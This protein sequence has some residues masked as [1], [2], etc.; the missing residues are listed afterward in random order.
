MNY[1]KD[2]IC[3]KC[4]TARSVK[5]NREHRDERIIRKRKYYQNYRYK[6]K[7]SIFKKMGDKC[8]HCDFDNKLALQIDHI[9][10]NGIKERNE[11]PHHASIKFYRYL[12]RLPLDELRANYQLLCCNCNWI[13]RMTKDK[14]NRRI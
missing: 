8:T 7:S 11:M 13:K 9:H 14:P 3:K 10:N 12:D 1:G 5:Y 4:S 6:Y 2:N